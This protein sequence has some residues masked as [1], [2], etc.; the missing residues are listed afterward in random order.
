MIAA[1]VAAIFMFH[2]VAAQPAG[3]TYGRALTVSPAE[4]ESQLRYLQAKGCAAVTVDRLI[5][6]VAA[7]TAAPCEVALTFDDGYSD[8]STDAAPLLAKYG[9]A[10]TFYITTGYIGSPGHLDRPQVRALEQRGM[11]LGAHT[12]THAD[13]TRIGTASAQREIFG[14]RAMLR[15]LTGASV[16]AFAYP[17]GRYDARVEAIVRDAGFTDALSTDA[18]HI[19]SAVLARDM[20][21]LPR[22]RVLRGSGLTL[23]R[24]V[25][26]RTS[27]AAQ[28][29]AQSETALAH[30]ARS[31]VEGN[32]PEVAERVAVAVLRGRF[33]EPVLKVRVRAAPGA[34]VAGIMLSGV[35]FHGPV[36]RSSFADDV[37][38]MLERCFVADPS[39]SEV[40]VWAV[41]PLS[42]AKGAVVSGDYAVPTNRTVFSASVLRTEWE[43]S[44]DSL[45][46]AYWDPNWLHVGAR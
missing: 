28:A 4:F 37:A 44:P 31:R 18:G 17:A 23:M 22:Y 9:D 3:G 1:G 8:A 21:A 5:A 14:S 13:L 24:D 32:A 11:E 10:G 15:K 16:T 26:G 7:R 41:V 42:T 34:V 36:S 19:D 12:V 40:D 39:V 27:T 46:D 30:I 45:G 6:D 35:K 29:A 43:R 33:A 25:L 38:A 2:H 20:F